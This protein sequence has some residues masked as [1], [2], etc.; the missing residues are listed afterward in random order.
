MIHI[1]N[2]SY[3]Y[4]KKKSFVLTL[5]GYSAKSA[6]ISAILGPN[7]SGKTTLIRILVGLII[8]R[9]GKVLICGCDLRSHEQKARKRIGLVLGD[10]RTFYFRLSGAQ[11]LEFFGGLYGLNGSTLKKSVTKVLEA[12]GLQDD[13][14]FQYMR[15][16]TG[17]KKRLAIARA[18]LHDP[19]VLLLDEPNS[20]VDPHSVA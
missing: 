2:L 10:E 15:Y 14:K 7:G 8:P 3:S 11:N 9:N 12:V 1:K 19:Q 4:P 17:M 6:E 16:S 18:L 5:S 13:A 20:G